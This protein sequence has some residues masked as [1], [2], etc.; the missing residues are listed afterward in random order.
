MPHVSKHALEKKFENKIFKVLL[1]HLTFKEERRIR[2]RLCSELL[3]PTERTMLAKRFVI[4]AMLGEGVSFEKI[5]ETLKVSP[6]TVGRIWSAMQHGAFPAS[7]AL[8]KKR[9]RGGIFP[10]LEKILDFPLPRSG[11]RWEFLDKL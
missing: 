11:R 5:Q 3:T 7:V 4:I 1:E 9:T 8:A 2:M 10:V 6:S